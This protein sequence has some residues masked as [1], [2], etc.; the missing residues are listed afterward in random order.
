MPS[1]I[2]LDL[3]E[4]DLWY[5]N[6]LAPINR[7]PKLKDTGKKK[8][9]IKCMGN[10]KYDQ[11]LH[12][13]IPFEELINCIPEDYEIYSFHIDEDFAHPRVIDLKDKI[14]TWDDTLDYLDQMDIVVS[15]CTSLIHAA[16]SMGKKSVVVVPILTY[17]MWC[18]PDYHTAWYA[19]NLTVFRQKEY[20]NW[21]APLLELKQYLSI[22]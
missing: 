21:K 11:D 7:A 8:I 12:R 17:Y 4:K 5:G 19:N 13:T 10:P 6:Y 9:G 20:D 14:K 1:P 2:Y 15:S 22:E 18:K 16:G 3:D